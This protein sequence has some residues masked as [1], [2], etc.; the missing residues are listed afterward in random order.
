MIFA[1]VDPRD[2]A[3][4][5]C[6]RPD[7]TIL[8]LNFMALIEALIQA[9]LMPTRIISIIIL[10]SRGGLKRPACRRSSG[11]ERDIMVFDGAR[12]LWRWRHDKPNSR[13]RPRRPLNRLILIQKAAKSMA[14]MA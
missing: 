12:D 13:S 7:V 11:D 2:H 9:L 4:R 8:Q 5:G 1:F 6:L 10:F 3:A 14:S